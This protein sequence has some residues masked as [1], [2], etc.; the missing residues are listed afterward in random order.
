MFGYKETLGLHSLSV[1]V[2]ACACARELGRVHVRGIY[3]LGYKEISKQY[4][5]DN[6]E[7]SGHRA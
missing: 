5:P 1:G 6:K 4:P 2:G 3:F 7:T